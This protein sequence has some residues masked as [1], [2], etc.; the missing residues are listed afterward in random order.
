MLS[1]PF[2]IHN[3]MNTKTLNLFALSMLLASSTDC[4]YGQTIPL[5]NKQ[6]ELS[7]LYNVV[8]N[9][10]ASKIAGDDIVY[11]NLW[12]DCEKAFL[13]RATNGKNTIE[14]CSDPVEVTQNGTTR[15]LMLACI[16]QANSPCNFQL[17]VN[18][19]PVGA[20][21][22]F[23]EDAHE[24]EL[25][26]GVKVK[27]DRINKNH[28]GDG[29]FFMHV[30][31]PEQL[32]PKGKPVH[33]KLTGDKHDSNAWFML[34]K[35]DKLKEAVC[36]RGE[37]DR[38]TKLT[39][40]N[41]AIVVEVPA[42]YANKKGTLSVNGKSQN[43]FFR[44]TGDTSTLSFK[45]DGSTKGALSFV[46]E[47][48]TLA[49]LENTDS[50][51]PATYL[52]GDT[53]IRVTPQLDNNSQTVEICKS[54][55]PTQTGLKHIAKSF[56]KDA[57]TYIMVS[58][59]QDIGWVDSPY[60]CI[61]DRDY[62]IVSPALELLQKHSDYRYDI[63][64]VL[65]LQE[66]L[67]RNPEKH[68]L[69]AT[70]IANGQLGVGASYTQPYEE[71][72]TAE[73]L[74]RQFYFGKRWVDQTFEGSNARTYW[75]VDVP[76]RTL[77]MPQIL[78]KSGIDH[79]QY[80]RHE[81][82]L[83]DWYA[84][85]GES[86]VR[87]FTPGHY[88]VA[89]N[90]LRKSPEEGTGKFIEYMESF[91]D[92]RS[93]KSKPAVVGMLSAE[94][95]SPAH[96]Y[97]HW[98]DKYDQYKDSVGGALPQLQH[99]TSDLF[100]DAF[101]ATNPTLKKI[102][103]ERPD[104]WQYIHGP[105]HEQA[106][107]TYR[108]ANRVTSSAETFSTIAALLNGSFD[109]YPK[110]ELDGIWRNLIY[111]DHGWGGNRGNVTDSLFEACYAQ[112]L[113]DASRV[114]TQALDA[115][116]SSVNVDDK[117]GIPIVVFNQLSYRHDMPVQASIHLDLPLNKQAKLKDSKGND[118]AYQILSNDK[119]TTTIEF[120]ARDMP[121]IGYQTF[122]VSPSKKSK[123]ESD[124]ALNE[125]EFYSLNFTNGKL[126]GI[127]DKELN[128]EIFDASK[129]EIGEVFSMQSVGN[130]AG[131]FATMQLPSM[132]D[133]ES[134]SMHNSKWTPIADGPIFKLYKSESKFSDADIV[135]YLK[136]YKTIKRID[137]DTEVN[138]F[139]GRNYREF[140]QAFPLVG[141]SEVAYEV[142]F[143]TVT[144]GKDEISGIAGERY[145]DNVNDIHPR[146]IA[147]WIGGKGNEVDV[148][149]SSSVIVADYIDPTDNPTEST[150]IQP[151]LFASR[152]SCHW[153]GDFYSQAGDH[154]FHFS[155]RSDDVNNKG[156]EK[157]AVAANYK[158]QA[159]VAPRTTRGALLPEQMSF[160]GVN[161][162]NVMISAVKKCEDDDH[163]IVRL[164]DALS[165]KKKQ[166]AIESFLPIDAQYKVNMIELN[167]IKLTNGIELGH[168][169]IETVKLNLLDRTL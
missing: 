84:P 130:G 159:V 37:R 65:I 144:V 59:H 49:Y 157:D 14:W 87:T 78:K 163:V 41:D 83:F 152:K 148:K 109:S 108:E 95:M 164:Y 9:G 33:F 77:Q 88:T 149:L 160:F 10:F 27:F 141:K 124:K 134:T 113:K 12:D 24:K 97:Y 128:K 30:L 131:E 23:H 89:S 127:V 145:L 60:K 110:S 62:I 40:D 80:S 96:T 35:Y 51:T 161:A 138:G 43:G 156:S 105:A 7:A 20:L 76:A 50:I 63:E 129:F 158:A 22:N 56:Y 72:Q 126:T 82:G 55:S 2:S 147:N 101:T 73:A 52:A 1:K 26:M 154:S 93:D 66:Y 140:R 8:N 19:K 117:A 142:P 58:S 143:G 69:I 120:I 32:A 91:E 115:I 11:N 165:D 114:N 100:F 85:D 102:T 86:F 135:R 13:T 92:Y 17:Y 168:R 103:G 46:C 169:S 118:V 125:S 53:L 153:L 107:T 64:D 42:H 133:Y 98:I 94:D 45:Y 112:A 6:Q 151:I 106:L 47:G 119:K 150:V 57:K 48:E 4:M 99:A 70:L 121:S 54:Y 167:P 123:T 31:I 71:M 15:F 61:E 136:L 137:F 29:A 18:D 139:N 90:F 104:L 122:Y 166:I 21:T 116:A 68:D 5:I 28:W 111:P 25:D 79:L 146:S 36:L 3:T 155:L 16:D 39:L 132:E 75:N 38:Y 74:V 81:R 44:K 34:F 67:V 162:D